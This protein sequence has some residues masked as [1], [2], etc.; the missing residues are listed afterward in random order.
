MTAPPCWACNGQTLEQQDGVQR[1][2]LCETHLRLRI[3][4]LMQS[5]PN[6]RHL[7]VAASGT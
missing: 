7:E 3:L 6:A 2:A 1:L 5:E 4:A